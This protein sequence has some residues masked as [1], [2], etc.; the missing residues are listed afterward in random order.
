MLAVVAA[1]RTR[2]GGELAQRIGQLEREVAELRRLIATSEHAPAAAE[3]TPPLAPEPAIELP[4]ATETAPPP[5]APAPDDALPE[6]EVPLQ[7]PP[8]PRARIDWER[9]FGVRAAAVLG[10]I[11]LALAGLLFFKYSIEHGLIPPWLRVVLGTLVGAGSIA[12]SEWSLRRRYGTTANALAGAG[13]VV[14]YATFWAASVRYGLIGLA[15]S[16]VLMAAV[17]A[18]CCTL[19]ARHNAMVI[20]LLGLAGGFATP[21]LLSS[22]SDRPIGLFG[23]VL[24][25]D[26]AL[27]FLAQRCRWPVLAL[28]SLAATVAYEALWIAERMGPDRLE[29]GL[30]ILGLFAILFA[31]AGRAA[32]PEERARWQ[33]TQAAAVLLPFAFVFYFAADADFGPHLHPLAALV[34]LLSLAAGW[35]AQAQT[36]PFLA[37]ATAS[38]AV[39]SVG[40]WV[41]AR[42]AAGAT[43]WE[44]AGWSCAIAAAFHL[45]VERARARADRFGPAP[46]AILAA[47]GFSLVLLLASAD[48]DRLAPALAGMVGIAA[49]TLRHG[50]FAQREWLH[51]VGAIA[52][53]LSLSELRGAHAGEPWFPSLAGYLALLTAASIAFQSVALARRAPA[54]QRQAEHAA[55]LL[56]VLLL[57][58]LTPVPEGAGLVYLFGTLALGVLAALVAIRLGTGGWLLAAVAAS[59]LAQYDWAMDASGPAPMLGRA[60]A[61]QLFG[62]AL[63]TAWPFLAA[64]RFRADRF[65]WAAAA[66][67]G[68]FWFLSLKRLFELRFGAD[69]VGLLPLALA[70]LS[71]L[72]VWRARDVWPADEPLRV[73]GLAWF[74]A[75]ALAFTTVAIPLQLER[76]W[77]TLGWA[78]EGLA[79]LVLWTRLDHPG[80][81]YFGL[82]L[83]AAVAVRLVANP[84]VLDYYPRPGWRIV[85]WLLYTYLVPAAAMFG[86]ARVLA[87]H[88]LERL[89]AW[90][91]EWIYR[92]ARP[93]GA[94]AVGLA[95]L[96]VVFVWLNLA[97]AD[98]FATGE[99]LTVSFARLPARDLATSITWAL[100]A[101]MLL[102]IGMARRSIGLRWVSLALLL[103]TIAKVFLYDLGELR[104]LYRVASLLGLAVSLLVVS[105][106]YQR[107][108]FRDAAVEK[109]A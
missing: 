11:A 93:F 43:A 99:T 24:L 12:A 76:E 84:A 28:V 2:A 97:I 83:L 18:A 51:L 57:L 102:G 7:I 69:F 90:E 9:L 78:L 82:A 42:G 40:A 39:A 16:F 36:V 61:V 55:A 56:P 79:V 85:N 37:L 20:A 32:A 70:A 6:L 26:I 92:R 73:E 45:F 48:A 108:V 29:L 10:G 86:A 15:P 35:V 13:A 21:L 80:L 52:V 95:G 104:D 14:L 49:L 89:R 1:R 63:F 23:Y 38:A 59:A 88:E 50:G 81:K 94:L 64:A 74:A 105:L 44:V 68:P 19:A 75:V 53:A 47:V 72:A 66:L 54:A 27:L 5:V 91:R 96:V 101:L 65:A 25:L 58:T 103:I 87:A 109:S 3:P 22:G 100:Y 31:A 77:I 34:V 41:L 30:A 71:V 107:F 62:V 46:P 106:A 33:T 4:R 8:A 98:W 60:L 67:A 17:T